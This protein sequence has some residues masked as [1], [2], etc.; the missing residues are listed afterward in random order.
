MG[1]K[2]ANP[3]VDL[4]FG[5]DSSECLHELLQDADTP[6]EEEPYPSDYISALVRY[7]NYRSIIDEN[8]SK[9]EG[10]PFILNDEAKSFKYQPD[11]AYG[12]FDCNC[13]N[14]INLF[15]CKIRSK[16]N[17]SADSFAIIEKEVCDACLGPLASDKAKCRH[18]GTVIHSKCYGLVHN[19]PSVFLFECDVCRN[20]T[21]G[22]KLPLCFICNTSGGIMRYNKGKRVWNHLSC[23]FFTEGSDISFKHLHKQHSPSTKGTQYEHAAAICDACG[24]SSGVIFPCSFPK[25]FRYLHPRCAM[26]RKSGYVGRAFSSI[27][28]FNSV[29]GIQYFTFKGAFCQEHTDL[30]FISTSLQMEAKRRAVLVY[31]GRSTYSKYQKVVSDLL[32]ATNS[33]DDYSLDASERMSRPNPLVPTIKMTSTFSPPEYLEIEPENLRPKRKLSDIVDAFSNDISE[34]FDYIG[35]FKSDI[36]NADDIVLNIKTPETNIKI[37]TPLEVNNI[38]KTDS[39]DPNKYRGQRLLWQKYEFFKRISFGPAALDIL[40]SQD[41][42]SRKKILQEILPLDSNLLSYDLLEPGE[43]SECFIQQIF[44]NCKGILS[45]LDSI[46]FSLDLDSQNQTKL[47]PSTNDTKYIRFHVLVDTGISCGIIVFK[48]NRKLLDN[49]FRGY[50]LENCDPSSLSYA[51]VFIDQ[52]IRHIISQVHNDLIRTTYASGA[53][54]IGAKITNGKDID[55]LTGIMAYG[56]KDDLRYLN[57]VMSLSSKESDLFRA[58]RNILK[59]SSV[60]RPSLKNLQL[61]KFIPLSMFECEILKRCVFEMSLATDVEMK[62]AVMNDRISANKDTS[63]LNYI[64]WSLIMEKIKNIIGDLPST[65]NTPVYS[66]SKPLLP[67]ISSLKSTQSAPKDVTTKGII[68]TQS[69]LTPN[70]DT[71]QIQTVRL[72]R[73]NWPCIDEKDFVLRQKELLEAELKVVLKELSH[74]RENLCSSILEENSSGLRMSE[75]F[76]FYNMM[77][78]KYEAVERWSDLVSYISLGCRDVIDIPPQTQAKQQEHN[79]ISLV[80]K[81]STSIS[82]ESIKAESSQSVSEPKKSFKKNTSVAEALFC[83]V[84]FRCFSTN[85]N[86]L[87]TCSRC[88][89]NCHKNCYGI[90]RGRRDIDQNDYICRRCE[91]EKRV[92]GGHWQTGFKSCSVIC[93]ICGRGGGAFKR[94]E[95]DDWAH[96][97]CLISLMPET[98]CNDYISLEPWNIRGIASWRKEELCVVC[99]INWGVVLKCD[100]CHVYAHPFCAWLHGFRF[101]VDTNYNHLF[102]GFNGDPLLQ[103]ITLKF[104]CNLHDKDRNW[105]EQMSIRNKR[106]L[107]R[108]TASS[109]FENKD[110]KKKSQTQQSDSLVKNES[111]N[112][113][114]TASLSRCGVCFGIE[115]R[116][117]CRKCKVFVHD[118]CYIDNQAA[119]YNQCYGDNDLTSISGDKS[120]LSKNK[121]SSQDKKIAPSPLFIPSQNTEEPTSSAAERETYSLTFLCDPCRNSDSRARCSI[122]ERDS[123]VLKELPGNSAGSLYFHIICAICFPKE[124]LDLCLGTKRSDVKDL[125]FVDSQAC[126]VCNCRSGFKLECFQKDC[127]IKFHPV[128][129][130]NSKFVIEPHS[131]ALNEGERYVAFCQQHSLVNNTVSNNVK[132]LL[133]FRLNLILLKNIIGDIASKDSVYQSLLRKKQEIL[134]EECPIQ[135]IIRHHN[136][137]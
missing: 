31:R 5:D 8:I 80:S 135:S 90:G 120:S 59:K 85:L 107:N 61:D 82:R 77:L 106:F 118:S 27:V 137:S 102:K 33:V 96:V 28:E 1:S 40:N 17:R 49:V 87:Y 18:C 63:C 129:G 114:N 34:T 88:Y 119:E 36:H 125:H 14:G 13:D 73:W 72:G 58:R 44:S 84:C 54:H 130:L 74:V 24:L 128:C 35:E 23:I 45:L 111:L 93:I 56:L 66:A 67:K 52:E 94:C 70:V 30:E 21:P 100:D 68:S 109:L 37:K 19:S 98:K 97:F 78:S 126:D 136:S 29:M 16:D 91:Y 89:M 131:M 92:L 60:S 95:G 121:L 32:L 57:S 3:N 99:G 12:Y 122:C 22:T 7:D 75:R 38:Q 51:N 134:N 105:V 71:L 46:K 10:D 103:R 4:E 55:F 81:T 39:S 50:F 48:A 11:Q 132:L 110:K 69:P 127:R 101:T 41:M 20:K 15:S 26:N 2:C 104:F 76:S 6:N 9:S 62:L 65:T 47:S 43:L 115:A 86:P 112:L 25:C 123:G 83:S 133:R 108:D 42:V 116:H 124:T 117:C 79:N 113:F 64:D 53:G